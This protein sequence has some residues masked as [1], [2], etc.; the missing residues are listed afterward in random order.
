MFRVQNKL[1]WIF[2]EFILLN[3]KKMIKHG[4]YKIIK[5]KLVKCQ[6]EDPMVTNEKCMC[7]NG[8]RVIS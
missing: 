2:P 3:N 5:V 7:Q 4:N 6:N 1:N 8:R